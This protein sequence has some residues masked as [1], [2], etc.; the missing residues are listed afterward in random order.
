MKNVTNK[1]KQDKENKP[2]VYD[3]HSAVY[4]INTVSK[5]PLLFS[6]LIILA[7]NTETVKTPY[8]QVQSNMYHAQTHM[9]THWK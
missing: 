8:F 9:S 1:D 4:S 7:P 2:K 6:Q 5:G 3:I